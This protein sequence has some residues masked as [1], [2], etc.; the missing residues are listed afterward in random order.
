MAL[1]DTAAVVEGLKS[2]HIGS[3]ALDVYE[4][5]ANL[6]FEDRSAEIID[7][8]GTRVKVITGEFWGQRGPVDGVAA[9]PQYLDRN[10]ANMII[11][12]DKMFG[13]FEPEQ[14]PVRYGLR[15]NIETYNPIKIAFHEW[16]LPMVL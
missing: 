1:I 6:F 8:D 13:T 15:T 2:G 11:L 16:V 9:D 10:Y 5:E 14:E 3:L 4:E 12:W 7:D